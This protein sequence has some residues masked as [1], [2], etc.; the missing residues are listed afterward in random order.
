MNGAGSGLPLTFGQRRVRF[1]GDANMSIATG[2]PPGS[3]G[4]GLHRTN[5]HT[6][7]NTIR[8]HWTDQER[9]RRSEVARLMQRRLLS[10]LEGARHAG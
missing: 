5:I 8:R 9:R 7:Q 10:A 1:I 6:V 2:L 3:E 4:A